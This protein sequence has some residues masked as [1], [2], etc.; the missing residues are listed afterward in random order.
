MAALQG[1]AE[2]LAT[3]TDALKAEFSAEEARRLIHCKDATGYTPLQLAL[4]SGHTAAVKSLESVWGGPS[5]SSVGPV[6]SVTPHPSQQR[7]VGDDD[8]DDDDGGWGE[9]ELPSMDARKAIRA[10]AASSHSSSC[11]SGGGVDVV[12]ASQFTAAIFV[13]EYFLPCRPVLIRGLAV[14]WGVHAWRRHALVEAHG[15]VLVHPSR[16]PYGNSFG[17]NESTS[18]LPLRDFVE[19]IF[20]VRHFVGATTTTTTTEVVPSVTENGAEHSLPSY[21]FQRVRHPGTHPLFKSNHTAFP[22]AFLAEARVPTWPNLT[23]IPLLALGP[24]ATSVEIFIGAPG[25]GA[26]MHYHG[27]AYNALMFGRKKWYLLPP[28]RAAYSTVHAV[29]FVTQQTLGGRGASQEGTPM[30]ECIQGS[31]DVLYIPRGWG[32]AV[33]NLNTSVGFV[34]EFS[35][36]HRRY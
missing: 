8:D 17:E 22:A 7:G 11:C 10:A 2:A 34:V 24:D 23:Q 3:L 18:P 4:L 29:D 9:P 15:H 31:G 13:S 1:N 21:V 12:Q 14:H 35:T 30:H 27:D 25:T 32:H 5:S 33:L 6:H 20:T 28:H 19:S 16:I 36:A 26:P